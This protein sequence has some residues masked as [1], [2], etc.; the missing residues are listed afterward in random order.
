TL[1][2]LVFV[3]FLYRYSPSTHAYGR[4][5]L[6]LIFGGG[7][8]NLV[9]RLAYGEV[10]DFIDVYYGSYHWPAF[11]LADSCISAGVALLALDLLR[12]PRG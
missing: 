11:N 7:L 8:G 6:M 3:F 9:D 1:G 10:I 2:A 4:H 12:S 5:A